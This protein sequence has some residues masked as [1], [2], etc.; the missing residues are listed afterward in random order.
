LYTTSRVQQTKTIRTLVVA[1]KLQDKISLTFFK[2][3]KW[4]SGF[5]QVAYLG[6]AAN[7]NE[8]FEA[9]RGELSEDGTRNRIDFN[10]IMTSK[11]MENSSAWSRWI[12][13]WDEGE[14]DDIISFRTAWAP[15]IPVVQKLS[16]MFP[17]VTLKF[18]HGNI[19]GGLQGRFYRLHYTLS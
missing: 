4:Q 15:A 2:T 5:Q 8:V 18:Y 10:K 12:L 17:K 13:D 9:I 11:E 14:Q 3:K 7:V 1:N 16:S 19:Y 6:E